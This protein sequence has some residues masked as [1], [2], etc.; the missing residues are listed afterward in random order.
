MT[1]YRR[2][3]VGAFEVSLDDAVIVLSFFVFALNHHP[4]VQYLHADLFWLEVGHVQ[5]DRKVVTAV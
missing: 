4:S 2:Q 3:C 1:A 5:V